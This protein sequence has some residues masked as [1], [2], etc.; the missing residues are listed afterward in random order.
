M[1]FI[2]LLYY[3]CHIHIHATVIPALH[4]YRFLSFAAFSVGGK[5]LWS[6]RA[7]PQAKM[8]SSRRSWSNFSL[9]KN[10]IKEHMVVLSLENVCEFLHNS[11]PKLLLSATL[12]SRTNLKGVKVPIVVV[13]KYP[14]PTSFLVS[15]FTMLCVHKCIHVHSM[16]TW[17][18]FR[19]YICTRVF[20]VCVCACEH[21]MYVFR[22]CK[23]VRV[24]GAFVHNMYCLAYVCPCVCTT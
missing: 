12:L 1:L 19:V 17:C 22:V 2:S 23:Y 6:F 9:V 21:N 13:G 24:R 5:P 4:A 14:I 7:V 11:L 10:V 15:V 20:R 3:C 18:A 16:C 8:S